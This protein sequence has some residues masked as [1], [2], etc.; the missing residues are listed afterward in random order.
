MG[1]TDG[2][3]RLGS[4]AGASAFEQGNRLARRGDLEG[5]EAAYRRADEDGHPTA[6]AYAGLFSEAHGDLR[7]AHDAY[8]RADE[9]GDGFGALRLG[10]L[11]SH[12]GD[13]DGASEAWDRADERGHEEPPF[14]PVALKRPGAGKAAAPVAPSEVQRSA[15]ANPVLIG[16]VTVL[17]AIIAVFLAY[18]ANT[19]LP[20]VPTRQ[21]K[22]DIANGADLVPGND[23]TEGGERIGLVSDM[24]PIEL[25]TGPS[26]RS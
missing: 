18:N 14:D 7:G 21:L 17:V 19:G 12:A 16:A 5:A 2:H 9:R 4:D 15:F 25:P 10:L 6:A 3:G 13:W 26:G 22:V 1:V 24:Q 8:T 20:F 11:L 23:V